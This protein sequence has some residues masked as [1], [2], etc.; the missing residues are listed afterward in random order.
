MR[1]S[2][3]NLKKTII[4]A[5]V[6]NNHEGNFKIAKKLIKEAR[7]SG[8][9]IVKFQMFNPKFTISEKDFQRIKILKKFLF[10][11]NQFKALSNYSRSIG[12]KF[13]CTPFDIEGARFLN[14]IQNIFKISSGDNNFYPLINEIAHFNKT[15]ILS[16]GMSTIPEIKKVKNF[17]FKAWGKNI[18]KCDLILLHCVSDYPVKANE[19]NLK[20]I[21][22]LKKNFPDCIIGYSDHT[23]GIEAAIGAAALGATIIE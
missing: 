11:K 19:A 15:I 14:K 21:L 9:D 13:F 3:K 6:G 1:K 4:V 10:T 23:V 16:T 7:N 12:I 20:A 8:A 18:K 5:E 2:N 22:N 17:I